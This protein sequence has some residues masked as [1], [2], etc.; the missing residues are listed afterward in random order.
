MSKV[1]VG[2]D[3]ELAEVLVAALERAEE[4][5]P[6]GKL[7][8]QA[9]TPFRKAK[10]RFEPIL[11]DLV[12]RGRLH[13]FTEFGRAKGPRFWTRDQGHF[14]REQI[15]RKVEQKGPGR[16]ND[17]W[18]PLQLRIKDW[19]K[20]QFTAL[21]S[22]LIQEGKIRELPPLPGSRVKRL[23]IHPPNPREYLDKVFEKSVARPLR[24]IIDQLREA[25]AP[26]AELLKD[27]NALWRE[28]LTSLALGPDAERATNSPTHTP[29]SVPE[30]NIAQAL[31]EEF[32]LQGM[33]FLKPNAAQGAMVA[34]PDL[35][36]H[37]HDAL[38]SK[39][40][41]DAAVLRLAEQGRVDLHFH[42]FPASLCESEKQALVMDKKGT[43]YM[44][45]VLRN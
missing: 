5:L 29:P 32:I 31:A 43:Y 23:S 16:P 9:P 10:D 18:K 37:L 45:I 4:P 6:L 8:E 41:F 13:Q 12:A 21:L 11:N 28:T 20:S 40:A 34:L 30:V 14:A 42:S 33:L 39:E 17:L 38:P 27:A 26:P 36:R 22:S 19:S 1:P 15:L 24:K 2:T 7:A 25:G 35:R 44:G 3:A